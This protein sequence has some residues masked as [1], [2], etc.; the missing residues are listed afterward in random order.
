M[1]FKEL[2]LKMHDEEF[3]DFWNSLTMRFYIRKD[4]WNNK[5]E[6]EERRSEDK[7]KG[8]Y[9]SF[10]DSG[11]KSN[12]VCTIGICFENEKYL[13]QIQETDVIDFSENRFGFVS[14]MI[15][16]ANKHRIYFS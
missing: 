6:N 11:L 10:K 1:E 8:L 7:T 12:I 3:M 5:M 16:N 15:I 9:F 4:I 2:I 13:F 14:F